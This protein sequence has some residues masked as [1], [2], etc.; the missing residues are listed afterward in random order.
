MRAAGR[1]KLARGIE[2]GKREG[3]DELVGRAYN[4]LA[5]ET[6]ACQGAEAAE[7]CLAEAVEF[8]TTRGADVWFALRPWGA[9]GAAPVARTVAAGGRDGRPGAENLRD[10]RAAP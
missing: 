9:V 2:M 6:I 5:Y 3:L 10:P 4:N 8:S 7:A 1:E